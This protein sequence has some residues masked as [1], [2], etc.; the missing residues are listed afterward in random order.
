MQEVCRSY[1]GVL[2]RTRGRLSSNAAVVKRNASIS[3]LVVIFT[4]VA[5]TFV[6]T[7]SVH[8]GAVSTRVPVILDMDMLTNGEEGGAAASLF[9]ADLEGQVNVVAIGVNTP[10]NKSVSTVGW[11]CVAAIA[12]FYGYPNVP[13]GSDMPDNAAP[14]NPDFFSPCAAFASPK[15]PAPQSVVALYRK[16]LVA[17]PD[18]S[19]VMV[20]TGYEE[21]IDALL[22]SPADAISPLTGS[23]LIAAKVK[24][25]EV[26]GGGYPSRPQGETN[27]DGHAGSAE[28]VA[29]HWPTKIVYAGW[30]VGDVVFSGGGVNSHHPSNSPVR[31]LMNAYAGANKNAASFDLIPV[32]HFLAPLDPSLTEVGPGTNSI[33]TSGANTFTTGPG[34]E[35]YLTLNSA[36]T[37]SLESSL[38]SLWDQ[39]PGTTPQG[40]SFTSTAP[41]PTVGGSYAVTYSAGASGNPVTLTIDPTST[42]GCSI[43]SSEVVHFNAPYGTCLIDANEPGD[44]TYAPATAQQPLQVA[45]I[46]QVI[47]Y[48][49]TPPSSPTIGDSYNVSASGGASPNPIVFSIDKTSTS[50]CTIGGSGKVTFS[51]PRGTCIIDANQLGNST[52]AAASQVQQTMS[53]GGKSQSVTFLTTAPS[54]VRVGNTAYTPSASA[55]SGLSVSITVDALSRG[56]LLRGGAVAFI[57]IGTCLIDATQSGDT[58]YVPTESQQSILIG[59]GLNLLK[60]TSH[61]PNVARAGGTYVPSARTNTHDALHVSLGAHSSGCAVAKGVVTFRAVGTCVILIVDHGNHNYVGSSVSQTISVSMGHLRLLVATAPTTARTGETISLR[62][63]TSVPF[64]TGV[65]TFQSE[66]RVLC[67]AALRGGVAVC[68]TPISLPK[69]DHKIVATYS[70]SSSFYAT[71]GATTLRLT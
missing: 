13:I 16:A 47:S 32:F 2:E 3:A 53:V 54:N 50:G 38:N 39:L 48:T 44:T 10:Y 66:G 17:Q 62:G 19:V 64:A 9:A 60:I 20:E 35:Y 24:V 71:T 37:A 40:F 1:S 21:N 52:Y 67:A 30:E 69:G 70:G 7:P 22:N 36:D 29:A 31:A 59:K 43:N 55:S 51:A 42:S 68:R 25:L 49:S 14:P 18:N 46:A 34:N 63:T 26:M 15:T 41:S 11:K 4:V 5:F 23:Q 58:T 56:C 61:A 28:D 57:G 8:A 12:Q 6:A 45:G 33:A 65:V 27:F